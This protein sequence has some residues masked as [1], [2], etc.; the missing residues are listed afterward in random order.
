ML[1]KVEVMTGKKWRHDVVDFDVVRKDRFLPSDANWRLSWRH[2]DG[3]RRRAVFDAR[4]VSVFDLD[5]ELE[6]F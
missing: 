2:N 6:T 1:T 3:E 5:D 4:R